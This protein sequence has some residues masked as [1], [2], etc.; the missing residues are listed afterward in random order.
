[1]LCS[2]EVATTESHEKSWKGGEPIIELNHGDFACLM[3]VPDRQG[4]E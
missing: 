3:T 1:M 2:V 4:R